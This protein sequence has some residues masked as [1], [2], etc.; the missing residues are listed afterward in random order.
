METS[1]LS[2]NGKLALRK[3][4]VY[5][6]N[7]TPFFNVLGVATGEIGSAYSIVATVSASGRPLADKGTAVLTSQ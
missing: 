3:V 2:R 5:S 6:W 4:G 7:T 1:G